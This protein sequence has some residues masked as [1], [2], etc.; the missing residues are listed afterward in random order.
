MKTNNYQLEPN[1]RIVTANPLQE[2][3]LLSIKIGNGQV[4]GNKITLAD[5][6]LAKGDLTESVFIGKISD[7]KNQE[8]VIETN[9]LDVN[10]FT[11][12]CVITTTFIN[13]DNQTLFTKVDN[14]DAPENGIA[15]F[16]GKYL[17]KILT[18]FIFFA[19]AIQSYLKAQYTTDSITFQNL[20][21]PTSPGFILLDQ[22]PSSIEKPTT[23]QGLGLSLLGLQKN[24]GALEVAP[25]WLILHPNLTAE[26][27]YNNKFPVLYNLSFSIASINTDSSDYYAGGIKTTLFQVN[28]KK[29]IL[30]LDSLKKEIII[31][32]SKGQEMDTLKI[33]R[34][35]KEYVGIVVKPVLTI[36]FAAAIGG[37]SAT[38]SFSDTEFNRWAA[39]LSFN[40]RPDAKDFYVTVLTRYLNSEKYGEDMVNADLVDI[41]SRLNY[42]ISKF[43]LSLEYLQRMNLTVNNFNDYRVAIIGSYKLSD[44]IYITSTFGKNFSEVNN[45]IALA[46]INFG[47]S[48]NKIKA[49]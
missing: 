43:C 17:I 18:I 45:I 4:G 37:S 48:K 28:D 27:M 7:L 47:F 21:T 38:N 13:Q 8:I 46:G 23:P 35:R 42:D 41:G 6:L 26:K 15:C 40:W 5:K 3:I 39:W 24:G 34:L 49:F 1:P 2:D 14:G 16:K 36:D 30:K 10:T 29:K 22:A 11:N 33:E 9:V 25:F 31:E 19:F 12:K 44:N 32:L 20:E